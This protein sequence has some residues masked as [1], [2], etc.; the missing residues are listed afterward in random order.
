MQILSKHNLKYTAKKKSS[1]CI[2]L[3][4]PQGDDE[5]PVQPSVRQHLQNITQP[6]LFFQASKSFLRHLHGLSEL[7][8]ELRHVI[9]FLPPP[10]PSPARSPPVDGSALHGLHEDA[11]PGGHGQHPMRAALS[12]QTGKTFRSGRHLSEIV[13]LTGFLQCA[14]RRC[15]THLQVPYHFQSQGRIPH[16]RPPGGA[17]ELRQMMNRKHVNILT[18]N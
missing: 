6:H 11:S 14:R 13:A 16:W 3:I 10:H 4:F 12:K 9:H 18:Q 17:L 1:E 2:F 5:E 15:T 8:S 7:P